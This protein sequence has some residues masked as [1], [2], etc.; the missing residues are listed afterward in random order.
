MSSPRKRTLAGLGAAL[1]IGVGA[2]AGGYSALDGGSSTQAAASTATVT[3]ASTVAQ[4]AGE[5]TVNQIYKAA[6]SSVVDITVT[7][8]SSTSSNGF[9][10][11]GGGTQQA[12]G[13]GFVYDAGGDIVTNEHVV[14]GATSIKVKLSGGATYTA[15]LVG[16]DPSTD[17]AVIKVDAPASALK[18]LALGDSSSV[19]VGDGVVA[20]GSPFG[21]PGTVT[22]GIVSALDRTIQAPNQFSIPGSIQT[23]AAINHGNSGGPLLD[24]QGKVIGINAQIE[25]DSGGNDGVGFAIPS[26]TVKSVA[27]QLISGGKV[28]HAF[29][30]VSL[31]SGAARIAEVR[32]GTPAEAAGLKVGDVITA[33]DGKKVTSSSALQSAIDAR[34]PGDT[35][36]VTYTRSGSEKTAQVKLGTRPS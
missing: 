15:K 10:F 4:T 23:D 16:S 25:S 34:R 26:N 19:E 22:T 7:S 9:P 8:Q 33:V 24:L 2:G 18:P 12:E 13:S 5:L 3:T 17:L 30:G 6:G 35:V 21:L 29:L 14:S 36:T 11:P 32:A 20:I 27:A 31:D 1:V 28:A